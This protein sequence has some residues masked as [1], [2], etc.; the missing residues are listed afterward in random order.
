MK[1]TSVVFYDNVRCNEI[2]LRNRTG[3]LFITYCKIFETIT[4][5]EAKMDELD[6]H[7]F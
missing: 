5:V 2:T 4:C 6:F 7:F 1:D 3:I